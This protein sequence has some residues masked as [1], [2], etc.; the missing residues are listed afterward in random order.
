MARTALK[1][2]AELSF[3]ISYGLAGGPAHS[4][5]LRHQ[6]R[7]AG[8][9][10][11]D[12]LDRA[13]II[14]AH[15]GGCWLIPP[16][17]QPLLIVYIG[18]TLAQERPGRTFLANKA[19]MAKHSSRARRLSTAA[20]NAYY[21]LRQPRRNI[22][23][24]RQAKTARPV[25][26]PGCPAVFIANRHDPWTKDDQTQNYLDNYDWA[27]INLPGAHDDIWEHPERYAA[28]IN[29]YARLLG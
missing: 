11:A 16:T 17:A 5:E 29:Y 21:G 23:M 19:L 22:N 14:I 28:I 9:R 6:L 27:F 24:V 7:R 8:L 3:A 2:K 4:R 1:R 26:F 10:Q 15:S 12:R 18:M 25:I 20:K 13:D